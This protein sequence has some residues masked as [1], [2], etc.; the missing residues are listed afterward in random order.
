MEIRLENGTIRSLV[1]DRK[2]NVLFPQTHF[3]NHHT[4]DNPRTRITYLNHL[5]PL[6]NFFTLAN[7]SIEENILS[8]GLYLTAQQALDLRY[9]LALKLDFMRKCKTIPRSV[10]SASARRQ[11]DAFLKPGLSLAAI[12]GAAQ[13]SKYVA[14]GTQSQRV[15][16]VVRYFRH[17][18][19]HFGKQMFAFDRS[20][21]LLKSLE[22]TI[23]ILTDTLDEN[24]AHEAKILSY[25][26]SL[27]HQIIEEIALNP[28]ECFLSEGG[29]SSQ[30]YLRDQAI[31]LLASEG[32]RRGAIA[33]LRIQDIF[34]DGNLHIRPNEMYWSALLDGKISYG[35][36]GIKIRKAYDHNNEGFKLKIQPLTHYILKKYLQYRF[37]TI[38]NF[39]ADRTFGFVWVDPDSADVLA[40]VKH[41]SRTFE[42]LKRGLSKKGL[43]KKSRGS[44]SY[45]PDGPE[46]DCR[47]HI[48]RHSGVCE[49]AT[50]WLIRT[51][52]SPELLEIIEDL[53]RFGTDQ[54]LLE[55]MR[56]LETKPNLDALVIFLRDRFAW[57]SQ[58]E[59]PLMYANR[60]FKEYVGNKVRLDFHTK[61]FDK[62]LA[63]QK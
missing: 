33:N 60:V 27:W 38:K 25:P 56:K 37:Q 49:S 32:L 36:P 14:L 19:Q 48:F 45:A 10:M 61:I 8:K 17:H 62:V 57:S 51:K 31:S 3:L 16:C 40:D 54:K 52:M 41:V 22:E 11:E 35:T 13:E 9:W 43:L 46:Y 24:S 30:D 12:N 29:A 4:K 55:R 47:P 50:E 1:T 34:E 53:E 21:S 2:G 7:F 5:Q 42:R 6:E 15:S 44:D 58:S 28:E 23:H 63:N 26:R 59:M 39:G 20:G 18:Y